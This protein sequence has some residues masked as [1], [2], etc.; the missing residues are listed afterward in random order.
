LPDP[1]AH[2]VDAPEKVIRRVIRLMRPGDT[3]H[4]RSNTRDASA[5]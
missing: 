1:R 3:H 4:S 2:F 5:R